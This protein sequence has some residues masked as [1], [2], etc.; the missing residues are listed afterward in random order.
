MQK[1]NLI[2]FA[3]LITIAG[4][5]IYPRIVKPA[6]AISVSQVTANPEAFLGKLTVYGSVGTIYSEEGLFMIIDEAGC[7]ELPVVVPFKKDQQAGLQANY[8]YSGTMPALGDFV[9][10]R[11]LLKKQDGYYQYEVESVTRGNQVIIKKL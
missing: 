10:V 7:C 11:G 6:Q 1:K 3:L 5:F 2:L 8:L 9:E 4:I